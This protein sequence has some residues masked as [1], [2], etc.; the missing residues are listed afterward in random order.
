VAKRCAQPWPMQLYIPVSAFD[1]GLGEGKAVEVVE[2]GVPPLA[3]DVLSVSSP[4]VGL[5][6]IG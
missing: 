4:V 1:A 6:C 3:K 5:Y 2:A